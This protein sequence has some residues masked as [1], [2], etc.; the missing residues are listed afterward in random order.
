MADDPAMMSWSH[1]YAI[2]AVV[3]CLLLGVMIS[4]QGLWALFW[5]PLG[6]VISLYATAQIVLPLILGIPCAIRLVA[7]RQ[8]LASVFIRL[9]IV[10][11]IWTVVLF[12][13]LFLIGYFWP[14]VA[15][16]VEAN[17]ALNLGSW[18]GIIA[19]LLSPL[20]KK[21]RSDFKEDFDRSYSR[22]YTVQPPS[23]IPSG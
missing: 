17:N 10:P 5:F 11:A 9:L 22:F 7:R 6:F 3:F 12:G 20:S 14:S 21:S 8:M 13:G 23:H 4:A 2:I 1:M 19:I 16:F 18:L 15:I